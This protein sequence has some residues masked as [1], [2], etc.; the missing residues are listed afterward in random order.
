MMK[1]TPNK[2][3]WL[4]TPRVWRESFTRN[5]RRRRSLFMSAIVAL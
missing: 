3:F 4:M 5:G 2:K 1:K